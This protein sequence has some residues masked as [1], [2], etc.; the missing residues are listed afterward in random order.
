[1]ENQILKTQGEKTI[2]FNIGDFVRYTHKARGV[3]FLEEIIM[4]L[5][6]SLGDIVG[7]R[8][9]KSIRFQE[10]I[11]KMIPLLSLNTPSSV[12]RMM[13]P[14][15][16]LKRG[17]GFEIDSSWL[18]Q[19]KKNTAILKHTNSQDRVFRYKTIFFK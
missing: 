11:E 1:M 16:K 17:L 19:Q 13:S 15:Y 9:V 8:P 7:I 5:P 10:R 18:Y 3:V 12:W 4:L 14:L 2:R 6:I